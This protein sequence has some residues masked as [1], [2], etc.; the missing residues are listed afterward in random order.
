MAPQRREVISTAS[1]DEKAWPGKLKYIGIVATY[2]SDTWYYDPFVWKI[3]VEK[4]PPSLQPKNWKVVKKGGNICRLEEVYS[5]EK[6]L[7]SAIF[8]GVWAKDRD[9]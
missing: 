1:A 4:A 3:V 6:N 9:R 7:G 8:F 5:A 2:F